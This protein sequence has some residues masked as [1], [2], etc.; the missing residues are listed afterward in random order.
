MEAV[1]V[2]SDLLEMIFSCTVAIVAL[3]EELDDQWSQAQLDTCLKIP[4]ELQRMN[5]SN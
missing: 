2:F 4:K 5:S 3:H 1:P